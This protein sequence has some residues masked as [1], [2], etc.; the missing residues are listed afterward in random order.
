MVISYATGLVLM[1]IVILGGNW[2]Y[3][4]N[5]QTKFHNTQTTNNVGRGI[6]HILGRM[7]GYSKLVYIRHLQN[8][9][10]STASSPSPHHT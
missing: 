10:F 7:Y 6:R 5:T 8:L 2:S 4:L 9:K 1:F 3:S